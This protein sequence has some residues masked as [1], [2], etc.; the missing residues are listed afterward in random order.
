MWKALFVFFVMNL[1]A[2]ACAAGARETCF[3]DPDTPLVVHSCRDFRITGSGQNAQWKKA[4]WFNLQKLDTAGSSYTSRFKIL[5]AASG[6]YVLFKGED[7][8][9]S[10]SFTKDFDKLFLGDVFEV[11]FHPDPSVPAYL[12]YEISPLGNELVLLMSGQ[13]GRISGHVPQSYEGQQKVQ[14]A[15][16]I[17]GGKMKPGAVIRSWTAELF[18]PYALFGSFQHMPPVKG[19]RWK[20][21][22]CRLDYDSGTMVKWAWAPVQDSFHELHRYRTLVFD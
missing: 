6:I 19:T 17:S 3:P 15:V 13:N 12:E 5:Y 1:M 7:A 8:R 11:F 16:H 20:A 2:H 18:F 21:N 10:S 9:I 22:F 14:K 4:V